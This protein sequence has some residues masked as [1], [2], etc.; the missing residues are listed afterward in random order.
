MKNILAENMLRFG[1]KNLTE[2]E[3]KNLQRLFEQSAVWDSIKASGADTMSPKTVILDI[4][5][6]T[7]LTINGNQTT[8]TA[9]PD[10]QASTVDSTPYIGARMQAVYREKLTLDA[11]AKMSSISALGGRF[12]CSIEIFVTP[13]QNGKYEAGSILIFV[14]N[15]YQNKDGKFTI[16]IQNL[17]D[18]NT[19][20]A[21]IINSFKVGQD[22]YPIKT[23]T[24]IIAKNLSASIGNVYSKINTELARLGFPELP[25]SINLTTN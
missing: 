19:K 20:Y 21:K 14:I 5:A 8:M 17:I 15:V 3:R 10:G 9:S 22:K 13:T 4:P 18:R 1:P 7:A 6:A 25:N 11:L 24:P 23:S 16:N 12:G 2:S